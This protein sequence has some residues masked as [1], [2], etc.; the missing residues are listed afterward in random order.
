MGSLCALWLFGMTIH[1]NAITWHEWVWLSNQLFNHVYYESYSYMHNTRD[2][3]IF[4]PIDGMYVRI[5]RKVDEELIWWFGGMPLNHQIKIRQN[6]YHTHV[7]MA[8]LYHTAKFK[9]SNIYN[10][11]ILLNIV[12]AKPP[13]LMTTT[14]IIG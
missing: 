5:A 7:H 1:S 11:I 3:A 8:I 14:I 13:N 9:S 6:F 2:L 10:N 4:M 12:G